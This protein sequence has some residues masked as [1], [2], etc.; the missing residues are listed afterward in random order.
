MGGATAMIDIS[1]GLAGDAR[2]IAAA[3][4]VRVEL[5]LTR[6]PAGPGVSP[7]AA[8]QSGEEY[9]LLACIDA[10][11]CEVLMAKW[12]TT[13]LTPLTVVGIVRAA[14]EQADS[15]GVDE[16]QAFDHFA[17]DKSSR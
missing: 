9:E 3:S 15:A 4:G 10:K 13:S 5:D 14:N 2:H 16:P 12:G 6:V 1:D 8:M 17:V 11:D 7:P